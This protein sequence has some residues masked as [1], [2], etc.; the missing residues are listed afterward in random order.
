MPSEIQSHNHSMDE[1]S[2]R[3]RRLGYIPDA[4]CKNHR[5][6]GIEPYMGK[7]AKPST[8]KLG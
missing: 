5:Y 4:I 6:I 2:Q 1:R 3:V 8:V 7:V